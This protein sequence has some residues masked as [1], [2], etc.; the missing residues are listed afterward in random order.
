MGGGRG[1]GRWGRRGRWGGLGFY[2]KTKNGGIETM[3]GERWAMKT[4]SKTIKTVR[5]RAIRTMGMIEMT[6]MVVDGEYRM[7]GRVV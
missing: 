6:R 2:L 7:M 4:S 1:R 5:L 3:A